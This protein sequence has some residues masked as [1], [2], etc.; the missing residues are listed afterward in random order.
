MSRNTT[1]TVLGAMLGKMRRCTSFLWRMEAKLKG[2]SFE[3]SSEFIGRP[4]ISI[5]PG[6]RMIL[7]DDVRVYSAVRANPL[8]LA[9]PSALRVLCSDA[10]LL[11]GPRVGISGVAICAG[12]SIEVGEGTIMGAG[13]MVMDTDF[14]FPVGEWGWTNQSNIVGGSPIKIGRGVFIGARAIVLKGVTIGDRAVIGAGAVVTKDV[15]ARHYAVGN[16][17]RILPPKSK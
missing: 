12:K 14:H 8:G 17:A 10:Q 1:A 6:G 2:V 16:P 11:L 4:M 7:G 3:G 5:E 13:A 15:P 9:Q